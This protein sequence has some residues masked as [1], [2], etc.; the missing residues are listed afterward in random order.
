MGKPTENWFVGGRWDWGQGTIRVV[1]E[2]TSDGLPD[3]PRRIEF[4]NGAAMFIRLTALER[5]GIFDERFGLYFEES[6]LCSRATKSGYTLWH[7]PRAV[8]WHVGGASVSRA[9]RTVGL[10]AGQY[11]RT[12]NR[13]LWGRKNLSGMRSVVFW[14]NVF[15]RLPIKWLTAVLSGRRAESRGVALGLRDFFRGKLGMLR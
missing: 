5:I 6:D 13:L 3:T 10:D 11:Y 9:D 2:N 14:W 4:V 8:V 12:R 7:V 1:R 15:A